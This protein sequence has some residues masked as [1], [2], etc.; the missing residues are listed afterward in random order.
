MRYAHL[1]GRKAP[2]ALSGSRLGLFPCRF[3]SARYRSLSGATGTFHYSLSSF[4]GECVDKARF[5]I[6]KTRCIAECA[7]VSLVK[8][9][10][11]NG[12]SREN[13][14]PYPLRWTH[15]NKSQRDISLGQTVYLDI[16]EYP[17]KDYSANPIMCSSIGG[18][19]S[20]NTLSSLNRE[21]TRLELMVYQKSGQI[22]PIKLNVEWPT[23]VCVKISI[24]K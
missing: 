5:G 3:L 23:N 22:F 4:N 16:C 7:E 10:M 21:V 1:R 8:I 24:I 19:G 15:L 13:F 20:I 2:F 17:G 14:I 9:I 18:I 12:D 6:F 11:R